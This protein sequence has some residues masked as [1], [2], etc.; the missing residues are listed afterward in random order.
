MIKTLSII[1][2]TL[3]TSFYFFPFEFTF[4]PGINT[5]M[6]LAAIGLVLVSFEL[7]REKALNIPKEL[8]ILWGFSGMVSLLSLISITYNQT[9]DTSYVSYIV[10]ASVWLSGAFTV[11]WII[12]A[13]HGNIDVPL[14]THYLMGACLFQCVATMLIVFV[15][16][17][18]AFVDKYI[19]AGQ[20]LWKDL[21]RLYG[22]GAA[23]DVAGSRFSAV[24]VAIAFLLTTPQK[25]I[26]NGWIFLYT[27]SFIIISIIGNMMA[28]TTTIGML[29]GLAWIF[30]GTFIVPNN[31][32]ETTY[33]GKGWIILFTTGILVI[34]SI[35]LYNT[36][37]E[38][39]EFMRFG[40]EGFFSLVETGQ[41][42][43]DSNEMLKSMV[44]WPEE[45][46]TWIIGDGY[47]LNSRYDPNYLG[48]ATDQGFYMGTDI[49]YLRFIFYFGLAG[50][51][52][53]VAVVAYSAYVC[54]KHFREY[55]WL[56]VL[57]L[58]VGL[59]VWAKVSTDIFLF[60]AL[61]LCAAAFKE[62]Q[63]ESAVSSSGTQ[64]A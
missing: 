18:Q 5:K 24:L 17:F 7:F 50:L 12:R 43:V 31:Q 25:K 46:R 61:F 62:P 16:A 41:W 56:F 63:E 8:L 60:F 51:F 57:A 58:G 11:C 64:T 33:F 4:L 27:L 1:L 55:A 45:L 20:A 32:S 44:V 52:W 2:T 19:Q 49:G 6:A 59:A 9:S 26:S 48:S 40:F 3:I 29:I 21:D 34:I 53:I 14:V 54:G 42:Q 38:I 28:R 37:P 30:V 22:I 47:F 15:P 36:I 13:V 23:V 10:S 35:V 39:K